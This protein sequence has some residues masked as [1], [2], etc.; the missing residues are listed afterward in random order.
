MSPKDNSKLHKKES[1]SIFRKTFTR[2][3]TIALLIG[4]FYGTYSFGMAVFSN[5]AY[6]VDHPKVVE[7][8]ISKDDSEADVVKQLSEKELI[9]GTTRFRFRKLVS[10]FRAV[11][12]VPGEYK[13]SQSQ[14][15][16]DIMAIICGEQ[17]Q[18]K[19]ND[20]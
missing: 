11:P 19:S 3:L 5:A 20:S 18:E 15:M 16:D 8:S 13:I 10:K 17:E 4:I 1:F 6:D 2:V 9:Y 7:I 14:G 12:F